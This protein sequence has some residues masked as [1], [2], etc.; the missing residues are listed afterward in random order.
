MAPS[1][2]LDRRRSAGWSGRA[3]WR[4]VDTRIGKGSVVVRLGMVRD[5]SM[6]LPGACP[7]LRPGTNLG[8]V[9][10]GF[11]QVGARPC[12]PVPLVDLYLTVFIVFC[13]SV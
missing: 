12:S 7:F 3:A 9:F 5:G 6:P 2:P 1:L 4:S 8:G 13:V 11:H 10:I